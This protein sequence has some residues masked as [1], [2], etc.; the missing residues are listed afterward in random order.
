MKDDKI[1]MTEDDRIRKY[2]PEDSERFKMWYW[3]LKLP[4]RTLSQTLAEEVALYF[5]K[6]VDEVIDFWYTSTERLRDEWLEQ[7]PQSE[8]EI[9]NYYDTNTTYIY[10]LSYWHTLHMNL[11]LIENARSMQKALEFPG[12]KYLDFGG[13]TGSN[14]I[15]FNNSGFECT[16]A[17]I[18]SSL[19]D[20]ARWRFERR[21]IRA[22]IVD[23]KTEELPENEFDFVTAVE[24]LE[25]VTDPLKTMQTIMKVTKPGGIIV[26][27]IPFFKDELRPM[28]LVTDLNVADKFVTELG[29]EEIWR[30]DGML[31]R[32]YRKPIK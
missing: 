19:L 6:S 13:G 8:A 15:L 30:E 11:G 22:K 27:W 31:I 28:H 4:G 18:S 21:N 7:N 14:I 1:T 17:D 16:I 25:H 32:Y 5:G 3:A 23:T 2:T 20:F 26:A 29:L 24:I 10:E 12:R 9:V